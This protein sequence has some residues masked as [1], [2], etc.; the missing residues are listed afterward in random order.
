MASHSFDAA[1]EQSS[2]AI[3]ITYSCYLWPLKVEISKKKSSVT[4][5]DSQVKVTSWVK[6]PTLNL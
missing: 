5:G 1:K 2:S 4:A 6:R 3:I